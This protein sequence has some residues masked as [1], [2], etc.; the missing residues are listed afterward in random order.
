MFAWVHL[1]TP[2]CRRGHSGSRGFTRDSVGVYG[3]LVGSLRRT[4]V[5]SGSFG[6]KWIYAGVPTDRSVHSDS[7]GFTRAYQRVVGYI[8]Y[9][10]G[11]LGRA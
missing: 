1:C 9:G 2:K 3:V 5:Y 6:V 10:V 11:S 8:R 7:R 4:D